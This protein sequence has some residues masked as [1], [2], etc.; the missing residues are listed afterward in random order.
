MN[1]SCVVLAG[2]AGAVA[3]SVL[4][5]DEPPPFQAD[6]ISL[7]RM[8]PS[9]VWFGNTPADIYGESLGPVMGGWDLGGPGPILHVK[10]FN[11]GLAPNDNNDAHSNGEFDPHAEHVI[12]FSG[13]EFSRGIPW[14]HYRHQAIRLQAAGD[15]FVV[16][17]I[18]SPPP[19]LAMFGPPAMI[20]GPVL[21]GPIN[22][23]SANQHRY[24]E[25]PSMVPIALNTWTPP[26]PGAS[27]NFDDMDALELTQFDLDGDTMHDTFIYFSVDAMAGLPPADVLFAPPGGSWFHF[28]PD[29]MLGLFPGDDIDALAVWD[30][31]RIGVVDPQ[32]DYA[33][34]SL[35]PGSVSLWGPDLAP[36]T[37]D[38]YSP[39]D[40][41]VTDFTG[42]FTLYL[43]HQSIGMLFDD[44]VD[45]LDV[46]IFWGPGAVEVWDPIRQAPTPPPWNELCI[47]DLTTQ[48]A[49]AGDPLYGVPDGLCTGADINFYINAFGAG[50]TFIGDMTTQG[51]SAS[52]SM[53]GVPDGLLTGADIQFYVNQ[54]VIGCPN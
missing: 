12:Y 7:D 46:E 42:V 5:A 2:I 53:Y 19:A 51:A 29:F 9:V 14:S 47:A 25:I 18:A 11:Y 50:D 15:R 6:P 16:N 22:L 20:M 34:F 10:D 40:I 48:G 36:N 43:S 3:T 52:S 37:P 13:D 35:A 26:V 27:H 32:M 30:M 31:G 33:L 8:S 24:N 1:L 49:A 39:A 17:G 21:P 54:W 38:D 23:L 45:A 28:A 44:N 41:F 4:M